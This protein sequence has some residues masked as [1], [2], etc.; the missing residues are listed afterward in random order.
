MVKREARFG[1]DTKCILRKWCEEDAPQ[2]M[3]AVQTTAAPLSDEGI[4]SAIHADLAE[5]EL[6]PDQHLVDAG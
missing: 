1:L 6:L 3:T 5:K 2:L 4:L